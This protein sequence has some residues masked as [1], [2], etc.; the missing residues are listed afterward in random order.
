MESLG[1]NE[2]TKVVSDDAVP[3]VKSSQVQ[4]QLL[5]LAKLNS[6]AQRRPREEIMVVQERFRAGTELFAK[7]RQA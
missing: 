1:I 6:L 2:S 3:V 5:K 4:I 7:L